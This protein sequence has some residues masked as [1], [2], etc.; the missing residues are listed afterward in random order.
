MKNIYKIFSYSLA[1]T[2]VFFAACDSPLQDEIDEIE[3]STAIVKDIE[4]TLTDD[5]Y[6]TIDDECECS[7]FGSFNTEDDAKEFI[8][9]ALN[10]V[11]P[12]LGSGSSIIATYKLYKG[13]SPDLRGDSEAYTV[14]S[15]EYDELGFTYG[16][17]S[18]LEFD[19]PLYADYKWPNAGDGDYMDITHQYYNGSATVTEVS[20]AGYTVAYGWKYVNILPD[21]DYGDYFGESGTDFSTEDEGEEKMPVYLAD[22]IKFSSDGDIRLVQYNYDDGEDGDVPTLRMYIFDDAS[23]LLYNDYYQTVDQ[24]LSF[25]NDGKD[26]VPD[27]TIKYT[28]ASADYASV[29]EAW[30]TK[31][32]DGSTSISQYGNYDLTL[33]SDDQIVESLNELMLGSSAFLKEVGQKYLVSYAVWMPGAG[34]N[35]KLFIYDGT[36]FVIVEEE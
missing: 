8:P 21:A 20:R 9:V 3:E 32:A 28:L 10:D 33:W 26:W 22:M 2:L 23:W 29:G 36:N 7:G 31:N 25:S 4:Y 13:S 11:F 5:D 18:S 34:T 30:A 17:F 27:N 14:T 35:S 1:M 15:A 16:N 24:I 6:G 12:A 19:I